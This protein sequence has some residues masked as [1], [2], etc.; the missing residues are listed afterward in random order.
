MKDGRNVGQYSETGGRGLDQ[1]NTVVLLP[2]ISD[3]S[4]PAHIPAN[5]HTPKHIHTYTQG[6]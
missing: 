6:I 2:L 5:T 3:E 4:P 1:I